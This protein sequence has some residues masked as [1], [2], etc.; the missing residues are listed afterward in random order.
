MKFLMNCVQNY[1]SIHLMTFIL[2][3]RNNETEKSI[4]NSNNSTVSEL[5]E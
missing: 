2:S 3:L 1:D 5:F 4:W